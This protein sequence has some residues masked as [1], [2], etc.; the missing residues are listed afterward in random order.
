MSRVP[1]FTPSSEGLVEWQGIF[2]ALVFS[3]LRA[4][5]SVSLGL[6]FGRGKPKLRV[7]GRGLGAIPYLKRRE[8][9][10]L[11]GGAAVARRAR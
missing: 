6:P 4:Q 2:P 1:N 8:F 7:D 9:I 10:T 5:S 3:H 11:L